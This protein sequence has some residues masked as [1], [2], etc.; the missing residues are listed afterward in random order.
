MNNL[1]PET[2]DIT[3]NAGESFVESKTLYIPENPPL[4]DIMLSFDLT[5]SMAGII[6]IAKRKA[7]ELINALITTY[8]TADFAFGVISYM[9]YNG[10]F[11]SCGYSSSYGSGPDYPYRLDHP[12]TKNTSE[13]ITAINGLT[14]GYGDDGPQSYTRVFYESYADENISWRAGAK[15]ILINFAD[16]VPHDCN[17]NE[18]VTGGIWSTGVD[19]GRD[20]TVGTEDDL[21][22]LDVLSNMA[23]NNIVLLEC[24]SSSSNI[25]YWNYWTGIT[26]GKTFITT[27][28][29]LIEDLLNELAGFIVIEEITNLHFEVSPEFSSFDSWLCSVSPPSYSGV[30]GVTI[31]FDLTYCVPAGTAGGDHYFEVIAIESNNIEYGRQKVTVH[32]PISRGIPFFY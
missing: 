15:K 17:L 13:V 18:G 22:L 16:N 3:V 29:D 1:T 9:D 31:G 5:G 2:I 8:P 10:Y 6:N 21:K 7:T 4:I 32:I 27:S 12:I 11:S 23:L 20:A 28:S 19:P 25:N 30:T 26:G 14:M 24:H